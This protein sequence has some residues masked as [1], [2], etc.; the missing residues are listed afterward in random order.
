MVMALASRV[1]TVLYETPR[2]VVRELTDEDAPALYDLHRRDEVMRWLDRTLS[3]GP[4]DELARM[5]RWR[6]LCG[7]GYGF[8]AIV[9]R[10]TGA[11]VGLQVLKPFDDLPHTDLGWRLHPAHWGNGYATEAARGAITYAFGTLGLDEL[12]AVTLPHNVKSRAVME[13][14]GM[15]YAGEVVHADLPHVLY[16]LRR[17]GA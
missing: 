13:R 10:E 12:A 17:D 9:L 14:L 2:L 1:V 8:F 6:T 7:N 5:A 16:L 15:T 11:L 4:A 3:T